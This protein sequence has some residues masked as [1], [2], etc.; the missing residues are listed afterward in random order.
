MPM[1]AIDNP[2][3]Y[4][5]A[6]GKAEAYP[7]SANLTLWQP[8]NQHPVIWVSQHSLYQEGTA[9]RGGVPICFPWFAK[10][11][12]ANLL[13]SHGLARLSTWQ[14]ESVTEDDN[15]VTAVYTLDSADAY[16]AERFAHPYHVSY[17]IR[18]GSHLE[19][20]YA[21]T[22][23]GSEPFTFEEAL[24]TYFAV[25]D[26]HNIVVEGLDGRD[27]RDNTNGETYTQDGDIHFTGEVD[28]VYNTA[29]EIRVVDPGWK[30]T[31]VITRTN[32]E[33]AIVWNPWSERAS[34]LPDFGDDEW[35]G[36]VCVEGANVRE[37]GVTI[38]PGQTHTMG[39]RVDVV[40][41]S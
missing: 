5:G 39:Y 14:R 2:H 41:H 9:I 10:G 40:A 31:L 6:A 26:V 15:A 19:L 8:P 18:M 12:S 32:S 35:T 3:V 20:S 27:Y 37:A 4:A 36:M 28:R 30:R 7:Y 23:T 16:E 17:T 13:P 1:N 33:S 38:A 24:H 25:S 21:V 22:N 34:E 29:D 11:L